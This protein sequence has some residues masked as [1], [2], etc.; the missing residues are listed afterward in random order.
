MQFQTLVDPQLG[1]L[2]QERQRNASSSISSTAALK[3]V[4]ELTPSPINHPVDSFGAW[5]IINL[6]ETEHISMTDGS[7]D[8]RHYN[9]WRCLRT[10]K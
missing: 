2:W 6:T 3:G 1:R 8:E 7:A 10:D 5:L 9:D 4:G